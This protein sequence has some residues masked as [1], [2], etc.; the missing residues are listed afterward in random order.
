VGEILLIALDWRLRALVRAQL[1]EDGW[2]VRAAPSLEVGL[3]CLA[4]SKQP[5]RLIILDMQGLEREAGLL[6]ELVRLTGGLPL[7][8]CGGMLDRAALEEGR[9]PAR[10]RVLLR[11]FRVRDLVKAVEEALV[12]PRDPSKTD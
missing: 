11:P 10:A 4:R 3:A 9:L 12:C 6:P 8:L 5:P 1:R 2:A 7:V